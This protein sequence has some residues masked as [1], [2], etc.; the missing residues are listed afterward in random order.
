MTKRGS[1]PA[2][3][4]LIWGPE[5]DALVA[6]MHID[7][8]LRIIGPGTQLRPTAAK[9]LAAHLRAPVDERVWKETA[10]PTLKVDRFAR[11][12]ESWR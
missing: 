12:R 11:N 6:G 10:A 4:S 3:R 1:M 9:K 5:A 2:R 8:E 7:G